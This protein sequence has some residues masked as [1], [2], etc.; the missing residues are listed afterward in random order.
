[1]SSTDGPD[2][3]G[4]WTRRAPELAQWA[5]KHVVNRT[6]AYGL[7][8][9]DGGSVTAKEALVIKALA[10]HYSGKKTIG[11]HAV[12]EDSMCRFAVWDVDNHGPPDEKLAAEN[13]AKATALYRKLEEMGMYPLLEDSNGKGGFHVWVLFDR[14]RHARDV[15][16]WATALAPEGWE[17]FPKQS[18]VAPEPG[19]GHFGNFIR[20]FGRHHKRPHWSRF[21]IAGEWYEGDDAIDLIVGW[22]PSDTDVIPEL[23]DEPVVSAATTQVTVDPVA[24]IDALRQLQRLNP[25][26]A[27]DYDNW[28]RV[29]MILY[30]IDSSAIMLAAWDAWSQQSSKYEPGECA[31]KWETFNGG[32]YAANNNG[33]RLGI[34]TLVQM[35]NRDSGR[36]TVDEPIS[37]TEANLIPS[38]ENLTNSPMLPPVPRARPPLRRPKITID[39][40]EHRVVLE[41]VDALNQDPDLFQRGGMLVRVLR[42]DQ[43]Q[44]GIIRRQGAGTIRSLP[45]ASLR[46]RMTQFAVFVRLTSKGDDIVE[47]PTHP[48]QWLVAAV[49]ARGQWSGIRHLAGISDAPILRPDGSLWQT[50]GYD[51]VTGVLYQPTTDFPIIPD[52]VDIDDAQAA[53]EDLR[54]VVCDF[55]FA[56]DD[57]L[58]AWFAALLTPLAR[59]AFDGPTPLFLID[60]NIRGAGKGLLV[61]VIGQIVLG[62]EM[63]VSSYAHDSE[64]M[65]K[66]ITAVAIAGDRV[67]HLDNLEGNFGNDTL[68]RALTTTR[69]KDRILGKSEQVDLPLMPVW[70]G[71]GNNV[72]VAADT[73]RRIIHV[74]LDVL[75]EK[76][77][78]RTGFRHP[79]LLG[80]VKENRPRLLAHA[81]TILVAYC[82]A[83]RPKH[84]LTPFGSF[85]G[86]SQLVR[87]AIVWAGLPDPCRTRTKL[88]E[89]SD[90]T[91]DALGQLIQAWATYDMNSAGIVASDMLSTLYRKDYQPSDEASVAMRAALECFVGCPPGKTP[92]PRQVGNK[93][94]AYRRRV[95]GGRFLDS[96]P[97]EHHRNGAVW[98]LHATEATP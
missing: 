61:Q 55:I 85:E 72:S 63:P 28:L 39:T 13:F 97:N 4:A 31:G 74:R 73:T 70:Y 49:D 95:V 41:T 69:W 64:E 94:R 8:L 14:P 53:L 54:E 86:W 87:E 58:A 5:M 29:G 30:D 80:W 36:E 45:Q 46:E 26:R 68:D 33:R 81:L 83:G 84:D 67:V 7:Y 96:N 44:D 1:M 12:G 19:K 47:V 50:P 98:R 22:T 52:D 62:Y 60:A 51:S 66:K 27:D 35:A 3:S 65:R 15:R 75:E 6:D 89:A 57:H 79:D 90:T 21:C 23:P 93:L 56:S 24:M 9:P 77:E 71:T 18:G 59:F 88:A 91:A 82:K 17:V 16:A 32:A 40:E 48:T 92:T 2:A 25:A 10:V 34:G 76:P 78:E 42:D 38:A 20:L 37:G 43:V 11:L